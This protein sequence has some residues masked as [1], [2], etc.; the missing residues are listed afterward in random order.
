MQRHTTGADAWLQAL[1]ESVI[2]S[3]VG[4]SIAQRG[5][6]LISMIALYL[7]YLYDDGVSWSRRQKHI[8]VSWNLFF[9]LVTV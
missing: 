5:W 2:G 1:D 6:S 7:I 8:L 9:F 4:G 3:E